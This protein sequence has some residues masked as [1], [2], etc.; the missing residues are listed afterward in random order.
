MPAVIASVIVELLII[1][2]FLTNDD[3]I[4]FAFVVAIPATFPYA[5]KI[6]I[7]T[8]EFV[9]YPLF[10]ATIPPICF[11]LVFAADSLTTILALFPSTKQF[12]IIPLLIAAIKPKLSSSEIIVVSKL[13]TYM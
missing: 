13:L 6:E 11:E 2:E 4:T 5:E 1:V 3:E 10:S 9:I 12:V 7:S 8:R